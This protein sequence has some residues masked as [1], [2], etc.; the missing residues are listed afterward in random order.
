MGQSALALT[1]HATLSGALHHI[2][3]CRDAGIIPISGVEAYFRLDRSE[4]D[5]EKRFAYHMTLFAKNLKGWHS[6]LRLTSR[7]YEDNREGG[8]FYQQACVDPDLLRQ[9]SEGVICMSGCI[10]SYLSTQIKLGDDIE[11]ERHIEEMLDIF[12]DNFYF[13]I[14]PHDFPEQRFVNVETAN[15]AVQ[16]GRPAVTGCDAH[17]PYKDWMPTQQI[18]K[19]LSTSSSL[20]EFERDAKKAREKAAK[21]EPVDEGFAKLLP[22]AYLMDEKEVRDL[23][24]SGHPDL[25]KSVVDE[26]IKATED[27]A[28]SIKPFMLDKRNKLPRVSKDEAHA[29]KILRE[30]C[31]EGLERIGKADDEKYLERYEY[32]FGVLKGKGVLDYFVLTGDLVRW[33]RSQGILVNVRGS[34]AGC[35]VSYLIGIVA[36]DPIGWGLLFERFLNPDRKG[37]PDIDLDF[38]DDRRDEVK[39]YLADKY[40]RDHIADIIAHQTFQPKAAL[41]D[42]SRA[43]NVP[44][45]E[46]EELNK[47]IDIGAEDDETTLEQIRGINPALDEFAEKYPE[48][49]L[50]ANRLEGTVRN[51]SKH[52]AGVVITDRPIT[53]Y[54]PL[55]RGKKGDHVT[56]WSDR[57]DF[58][59]VSDHGL[60]KLDILGIKGLTKQADALDLIEER[61]GERPHLNALGVMTD[62]TDVDPEVIKI[63]SEGLTLGVWQFASRGITNLLKQIKPDWAG[64]LCAANALYRPGPMGRGSTWEYADLKVM[65][66]EE[67]DYWHPAVRDVLLETY[68]IIAY[69]EQV[70]NVCKILGGFTGGQ[71]DSMRKAMGKLYRLKGDAAQQFMSQFKATWDAG[72]ESNQ[73]DRELSEEIWNKILS[74]GGYGFNK[75]HSASYAVQ[76]YQDAWLKTYFPHEFYCALLMNPP[77]SVESAKG[78]TKFMQAVFRE[79]EVFGVKISPPDINTSG[80]RFTLDGDKLRYGLRAIKDVGDAAV[81]AI[82]ENRPY[83]SYDDFMERTAKKGEVKVNKP[84]REGLIESG[85]MDCWGMRDELSG[86]DIARME[87]QRLGVT[88][89]MTGEAK[90]HENLIAEN[91]YTPAEIDDL[92]DGQE[93][94]IGGEVIDVT[95]TIVKKEGKNKG[96]EM[97][98]VTLAFGTSQWRVTFFPDTWDFYRD[99]IDSGAMM[100]AGKKDTWKNEVSIIANQC[101]S[102]E[103]WARDMADEPTDREAAL[104]S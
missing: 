70:M 56:S 89:T 32:E 22:T 64:D 76:A 49:W 33:A 82:I 69:Q 63:F 83:K 27:L 10:S 13:E 50:H 86:T 18:A 57:A 61:H 36:I 26:S 21:G 14:Q 90:Q 96:R 93:V 99:L 104:A 39:Q 46:V 100:I 24:A 71:A 53:D 19:L 67:L 74:F 87:K 58:P 11:A 102:I 59:A 38:Q 80:R 40:G 37:L 98:W 81:Q 88:I 97:G 77:S 65:P 43:L 16:Y 48:V 29:E 35:L 51:Q 44:Y 85:A 23:Y 62:P 12:R 84:A 73:V 42:V 66:D 47:T 20:K 17:S 34:A 25:P 94:I 6:L 3:A 60:V 1:D 31:Q 4:R 8:G 72:C 7:A 41:Q 103:D 54:I 95:D 28:K 55:E 78:K 2:Q 75:S 68:G 30:W 101:V 9:H 15:Y 79:S 91:I 5:K 45:T 92:E 52:A